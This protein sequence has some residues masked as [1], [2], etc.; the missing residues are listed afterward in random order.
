MNKNNLICKNRLKWQKLELNSEGLEKAYKKNKKLKYLKL[1]MV[2]VEKEILW[3]FCLNMGK[4]A[5]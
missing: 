5:F 4:Y 1:L 3:R 2:R